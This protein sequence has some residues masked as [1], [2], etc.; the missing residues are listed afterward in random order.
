MYT[1]AIIDKIVANVDREDLTEAMV[2]Q[3]LNNRQLQVLNFDNFSFMEQTAESST[4]IAQQSYTVP[5]D[6]KDELH[7]WIVEG[8]NKNIPLRWSESEAEKKYMQTDRAGKPTNYWLWQGAYFLYPIPDKV[9]TMKAKYYKYLTDLTNVDTEENVLVQRYPDL[10][11]AG[12]TSDSFHYFF[13]KEKEK[14]W[15]EKWKLQFQLLVR[16]E[17][18]RPHVSSDSRFGLRVK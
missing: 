3:Y 4:V 14:E 7:L 16:R 8:T 9:Y 18:K 10:M 2:L 6:Y 13:E 1:S 12:G 5:S 11:I 17:G 15:E